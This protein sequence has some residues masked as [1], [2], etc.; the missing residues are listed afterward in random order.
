MSEDADL[1]SF[2]ARVRD[3]GIGGK[4]HEVFRLLD[5][6][7]DALLIRAMP[8]VAAGGIGN[9]RFEAYRDTIRSILERRLF[10]RLR[11]TMIDLDKTAGRLQTAVYWATVVT[12]ALTGV[13]AVAAVATLWRAC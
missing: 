1:A 10:E 9:A 7:D 3:L 11:Q 13:A 8:G 2:I 5:A 12:A 6:A 4:D